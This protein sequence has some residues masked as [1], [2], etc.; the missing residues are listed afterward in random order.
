MTKEALSPTAFLF[1]PIELVY[2][3]TGEVHTYD[4]PCQIEA[5][6]T[7]RVLKTTN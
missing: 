7:F 1:F 4:H 6:R 5:G 3:D 2:L